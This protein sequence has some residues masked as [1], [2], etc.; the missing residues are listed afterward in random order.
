MFEKASR[1]KLKFDTSKGQISVEDLW[2]LPLTGNVSLD[3][4]A[5]SLDRQLKAREGVVSFVKPVEAKVNELQLKFDVVK[6]IIDVKKADNAAI[7]DARERAA[8]K[9]RILEII[10]KKQDASLENASI[11]VDPEASALT[12]FLF[13]RGR[14]TGSV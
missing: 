2:D 7:A 10:A 5:I 1:L 13:T 6:H 3:N 14:T 11:L 9:A 12:R 8:K 4:I